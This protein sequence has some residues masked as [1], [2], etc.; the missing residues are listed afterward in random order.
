MLISGAGD[1]CMGV[2]ELWSYGV[3]EYGCWDDGII[4]GCNNLV[5]K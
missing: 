3:M 2:V 5:S 1:F 4:F